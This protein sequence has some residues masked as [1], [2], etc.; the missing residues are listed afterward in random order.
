MGN[1]ERMGVKSN[2]MS[3]SEKRIGVGRETCIGKKSSS[4]SRCKVSLQSPSSK[5][6][7][8]RFKKKRA[9]QVV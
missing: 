7:T 9:Q 5:E 8:M 6:V 1:S 4:K 2:W 3:G